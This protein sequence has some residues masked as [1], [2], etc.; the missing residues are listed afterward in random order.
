MRARIMPTAYQ[1][2]E[3]YFP[4]GTGA[5]TFDAVYRLHEP[6]HLLGPTYMNQAHNDWLDLALTSGIPGIVLA[7][8]LLACLTWRARKALAGSETGYD[9]LLPR[10][11]LIGITVLALASLS[12][13]PLRVPSLACLL[14]LLF[15]WSGPAVGQGSGSRES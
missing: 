15:V 6:D 3:T 1:M 9:R 10:A 5:G 13:Y 2:L 14:V 7:L 12:D 8:V 4:W 11:A